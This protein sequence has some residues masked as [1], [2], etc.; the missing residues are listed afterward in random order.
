M[1]VMTRTLG[2]A[3]GWDHPDLDFVIFILIYRHIFC[4]RNLFL[5]IFCT[6]YHSIQSIDTSRGDKLLLDTIS[7]VSVQRGFLLRER[8]KQTRRTNQANLEIYEFRKN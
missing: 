7:L 3:G 2:S 1:T 4:L 5:K 6:Q 8:K